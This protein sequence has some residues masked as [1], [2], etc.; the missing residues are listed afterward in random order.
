MPIQPDCANVIAFFGA[1]SFSHLESMLRYYSTVLSQNVWQDF[2]FILATPGSRSVAELPADLPQYI[3]S[4]CWNGSCDAGSIIYRQTGDEIHRMY[5]DGKLNLHLICDDF[6]SALFPAEAPSTLAGILD[7]LNINIASYYYCILR[8]SNTDVLSRQRKLAR[9]I[10]DCQNSGKV[11]FPYLLSLTRDDHS[12]TQPELLWRAL[13]C[14]ILVISNGRRHIITGTLS[15]LGYTSLN[16]DEK[17]L[18]NL[19]RQDLL[20][21]LYDHCTAS[22]PENQAWQDLLQTQAA[23]PQGFSPLDMQEKIRQWLRNQIQRDFPNLS[24]NQAQDSA[25]MQNFRVLSGVLKTRSTDSLLGLAMK[26]FRLNL[27]SQISAASAQENKAPEYISAR[28]YL[29][30]LLAT[31][32]LRPNLC[33]FPLSVLETIVHC[34][35]SLCS[36]P[37]SRANPSYPAKRF[38]EKPAD[39]MLKCSRLAEDAARAN[40]TEELIPAYARAYGEMFTYLGKLLKNAGAVKTEILKLMLPGD[41]R[42]HLRNKYPTYYEDIQNTLNL[43]P[44]SPFGVVALYSETDVSPMQAGIRRALEQAD[45]TL[46]SKMSPGFNSSFIDAIKHEFSTAGT[47]DTFLRNYLNN[48]RR[49]FLNDLVPLGT[50]VITY[51][52]NAQLSNSNW[53]TAHQSNTYF[54]DNDNVERLDYFELAGSH[55]YNTL[56]DYLAPKNENDKYNLFFRTS[57]SSLPD[58]PDLPESRQTAEPAALSAQQDSA[59]DNSQKPAASDTISLRLSELNGRTLLMWNWDPANTFYRVEINGDRSDIN[60][61]RYYQSH[62][63]DVT[64]R[65]VPGKNVVVLRN[66]Q[67][68]EIARAELRG[69][70]TR[71]A[72]RRT[73]NE[74]YIADIPA[75]IR[76]LVVQE[77]VR[78][79]GSKGESRTSFFYYPLEPIP[80]KQ[81]T[82]CYEGLSF[83]GDWCLISDPTD[84]FCKYSPV[85]RGSL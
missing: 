2:L 42:T 19:R 25:Q 85:C 12:L 44:G 33:A 41:R 63:V 10:L 55:C 7:Q 5:R 3:R 66:L 38:M 82:V 77:A 64:D 26:F 56:E 32:V 81:N 75:A 22:Y 23:M 16:A 70:Q 9:H 80:G 65:L 47:M 84:R 51:F 43:I 58:L 29:N 24:P 11:V 71:I 27:S 6:E 4:R 34:L 69:P 53:A 61:N 78:V 35:S 50:A 28:R 79:P 13:M 60:S 67:D 14:E 30:R 37:P 72:Y 18:F 39:Y 46:R 73:A 49:L 59:L 40:V 1:D 17:E 20:E 21:R 15:S 52:C 83:R 48:Q 62:G 68:S 74:L 57:S 76:S 31:L 45:E 8:Q 54:V 36:C